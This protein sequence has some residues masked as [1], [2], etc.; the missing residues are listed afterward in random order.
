MGRNPLA[1]RIR[2]RILCRNGPLRNGLQPGN[3]IVQEARK[4]AG[5]Q[6]P[7][8]GQKLNRIPKRESRTAGDRPFRFG[9]GRGKRRLDLLV[10]TPGRRNA[11]TLCERFLTNPKTELLRADGG[12]IILANGCT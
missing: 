10:D 1:A 6:P 12:M 3:Q 7:G 2:K 5:K 8:I 9:G 4:S 11:G